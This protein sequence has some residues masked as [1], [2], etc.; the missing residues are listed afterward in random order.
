MVEQ[1]NGGQQDQQQE[2]FDAS[3][4]LCRNPRMIKEVPKMLANIRTAVHDFAIEAP[5]WTEELC[6]AEHGGAEGV[7]MVAGSL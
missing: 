6:H 3:G 4:T 2:E 7:E 1:W 5:L